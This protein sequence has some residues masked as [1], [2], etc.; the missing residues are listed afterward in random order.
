MA[1]ELEFAKN[2]HARQLFD[3]I[4]SRYDR[5]S[6]LLSFFQANAWRKFLVSR[7]S[8]SPGDTLLDICTGTAGVA[9]DMVEATGTTVV[10]VD[11]SAEMLRF[12]QNNVKHEEKT[13]QV[14]LVLGRAETLG[15]SDNSFDAVCFTYL[16]RYVDKPK[17]TLEEIIRV[18]KPHGQLISLEFGV[19]GNPVIRQFWKAYTR[20]ALPL[21]GWMTSPSWHYV[22]N[23]LGPSITE[24][25]KSH[26]LPDIKQMWVDLGIANVQVKE[27]TMGGG[28]VMWGTKDP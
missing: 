12:A 26:P 9:L 7:L 14:S 2:Q 17:A 16:L 22:G 27:L 11:L 10:G 1:S 5:H 15:F 19:P 4:A 18:L 23:F 13:E 24:F 25:Y 21:A 20:L 28:V 6:Q 3:G 8:A